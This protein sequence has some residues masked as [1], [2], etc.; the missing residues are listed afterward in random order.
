MNPVTIGVKA[1][2]NVVIIDSYAEVIGELHRLVPG[3]NF[4]LE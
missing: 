2:L 1:D 4:F 3:G